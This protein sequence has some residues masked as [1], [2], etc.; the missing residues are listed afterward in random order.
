MSSRQQSFIE[1]Q[2]IFKPEQS[3]IYPAQDSQTMPFSLNTSLS[4]H[5]PLPKN[6]L[7]NNKI[8]RHQIPIQLYP[9]DNH[10]FRDAGYK[11][12]AM[13]EG[14]NQ[15]PQQGEDLDA[16]SSFLIDAMDADFH[17]TM[18]EY[19]WVSH[20][21][22]SRSSPLNAQFSPNI[23]HPSS[24]S[25]LNADSDAPMPDIE[26]PP[27]PLSNGQSPNQA[28]ASPGAA[29]DRL[30]P[31][32][33]QQI[34][35]ERAE[36]TAARHAVYENQVVSGVPL[37]DRTFYLCAIEE[38]NSEQTDPLMT[39]F[40]P[41]PEEVCGICCEKYKS[42][43]ELQAI[44]LPC[45]HDFHRCCVTVWLDGWKP[46]PGGK[47]NTCPMC[48]RAFDIE[49]LSDSDEAEARENDMLGFG[50]DLWVTVTVAITVSLP[51]TLYIHDEDFMS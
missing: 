3:A 34:T 6:L 25:T 15:P 32:I 37:L 38:G 18:A 33:P 45:G 47:N 19:N 40:V 29:Q 31:D 27:S 49:S 1:K 51:S 14:F 16:E 5:L 39:H 7:I 9:F 21:W 41:D 23:P 20:P 26:T 4:F 30:S 13:T 28:H 17:P 22:L 11:S 50:D 8:T 12:T 42:T 46:A 44:R 36:W 35:E 48:R 10:L 2:R 43:P 24:D